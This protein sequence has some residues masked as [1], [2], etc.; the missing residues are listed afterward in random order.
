[1]PFSMG[2][3]SHTIDFIHLNERNETVKKYTNGVTP[4]VIGKTATGYVTVVTKNE[5][6]ETN[7]N[8]AEFE[9]LIKKK[10]KNQ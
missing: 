6:N 2:Y 8:V 4:C 5:M 7:G 1:M 10:L 3:N 9:A